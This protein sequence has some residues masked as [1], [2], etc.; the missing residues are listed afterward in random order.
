M[1]P[2]R[3]PRLKGRREPK[4]QNSQVKEP[5]ADVSLESELTPK[6][7]G[8]FRRAEAA[9]SFR[10]HNRAAGIRIGACFCALF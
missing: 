3:D 2:G 9:E 10:Y 1:H 4:G 7:Q 6:K 5:G 8:A